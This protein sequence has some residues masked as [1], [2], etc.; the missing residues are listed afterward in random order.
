MLSRSQYI[1]YKLVNIH[2][3]FNKHYKKESNL[4]ADIGFVEHPG[5]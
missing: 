4:H 3:L 5:R 2:G 1:S